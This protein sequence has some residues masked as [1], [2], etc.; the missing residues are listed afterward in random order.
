MH[1]VHGYGGDFLGQPFTTTIKNSNGIKLVHTTVKKPQANAI[2]ERVHQTIGNTLRTMVLV[3]LPND[4]YD[5]N[6]LI[7]S[8]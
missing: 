2:C 3:N 6:D 7:D 5:A 4:L 8:G 1:C